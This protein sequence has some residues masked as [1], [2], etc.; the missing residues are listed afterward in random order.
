MVIAYDCSISLILVMYILPL[1]QSMML[2][3]KKSQ[4]G[5]SLLHSKWLTYWIEITFL[6]IIEWF[7]GFLIP[8]PFA[9]KGK[10]WIIYLINANILLKLK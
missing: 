5:G 6:N 7:V 4:T 3:Q 8:I 1:V 10:I 2:L 9:Y